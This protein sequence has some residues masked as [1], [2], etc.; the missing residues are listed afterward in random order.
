MAAV[1]GTEEPART[2]PVAIVGI[3]CRFAGADGPEEFWRLLRDGVDAVTELPEGRR[4]HDGPGGGRR[5]SFLAD[6][7]RFD[8]GFFGISPREAAATDPQQRLVLE[9]CWE[10]LED[11]GIVPATLRGGRTGVFVG[12]MRDDYARL[13][14]RAGAA[15]THHTFTGLQRGL[16]A[17]RVSYVCGLRGP[18]LTVDTGQS[19]S[20]TAVHLACRSLLTGESR[21]ALAGGVGLNLDAAGER[22]AAAFGGLSPD[23]R[24]HTFDARANGFVRGE[25]GGIV[26]LK[27]LTAALAAGDRI[28]AVIDGGAVN[29]D[30][31]G[32]GLTVPDRE[33]QEELLRLAY[34]NAG[35]DPARVG[36]VE[37][38]GTGTPVGDPVEAAALG[39]VLGAVRD[40][41]HPLPVGSV[42][43]NLG[44]LEGA[45]GISGLIKAVLAV[46]H[47]EL[48][49][50]LH[51]RS[52]H[53]AIPL[54]AL[55]LRV[56]T[57]L[58]PWA[59]A[60]AA[61]IAGVS[62]FGIG[63]SNCHLVISAPPEPT[64][65]SAPA[66]GDPEAPGAPAPVVACVVSGRTGP[67]LLAQADRLR[68]HVAD[69]PEA[70]PADLAHSLA[71]TRT[72]F[73][74]RAVLTVSDREDLLSGL[75]A[76]AAGRRAPGVVRGTVRPPGRTAFLFAGQGGQRPGMGRELYRAFPAYAEAF[77]A[78][79]RHL[80]PWLDVPLR[81]VVFT[82]G[83]PAAALLDS[84]R[85]TQAAMFT[86]EVALHRLLE[87]FGVRPD[88]VAGH[89]VGELAAAHVADVLSL[90]DAARL[91]AARGRLM[92]SLPPGGAMVA[93]RAAEDEVREVLAAHGDRV[94][95]AAVNGPAATVVSGD[96]DDVAEV[97]ATLTVRGRE[98]RR[99]RIGRALH[100]AHLDPVLDGFRAAMEGLDFRPARLTVVSTLT[101]RPVA[102]DEMSTPEYWIRQARR[103][104]LFQDAVRA[105]RDAGATAFLGL[106]A[107]GS[108]AAM[109]HD[110]LTGA[111]TSPETPGPAPAPDGAATPD[112]RAVTPDDRAVT[113]DGAATPDDGAVT[114]D[115]ARVP[116]G[117]G[118]AGDPVVVVSALRAR[119][120]EPRALF[121]ALG[122]LY[123]R[124]VPV[125]WA[126]AHA[127]RGA[128]RVPL[129][130]YRFQRERYWLD[131]PERPA[132]ADRTSAG[133][134]P[135]TGPAAGGDRPGATAPGARPHPSEAPLD[136][137]L[138][139][140]AGV[141]GHPDPGAV[142]PH[143]TFHD[144][145]FDSLMGVELCER[146]GEEL[147]S[148]LP[149]TVLFDHP[150]PARLARHL[151]SVASAADRPAAPGAPPGAPSR[152]AAGTPG[153]ADAA[154]HDPVVVVGMACSY[155]GGAATPEELWRLAA[156][157]TDA[158]GGFPTDR[159]WDLEALY[160]A[161]PGRAGTSCTRQGGFLH[162]AAEFDAAFFGMSPREALTT[163]P[164]QRLLL[165]TAWQAFESAG[166]DPASVRDSRTA[167]FAGVMHHDYAPRVHTVP[168]GLEG[169]LIT[170]N[171]SS[172]VSGRLSYV[173]G[174]RGPAVTVDTACSS[175][176]VA[177]HLAAQS[178]RRGECTLALAGGVSVMATPEMFV[179]FSRLRAL[180]PDGRCKPFS[181]AADGTAWAEGAGLLVLERL[182]DAR[183]N[184]HRVLAVLRGSAVNQ[185]GASNGLSAPSGPA[186]ERVI[187][188]ALADAGL[189]PA[190][191]DAVEA[192]GTGTPLGDPIEARALLA[193]YGQDRPAG[194]PLLLGSLKSNIGHAQ[195]AAGV[196]GVIKT[197]LA[198]RHGLLPKIL[199]LG[200][201][202]AHVDWDGGGVA[203][204]AE[205]TPWPETGRP[206]RAAVS[207]FGISGTNAHVILEQPPK[208][209]DPPAG[210]TRPD[211]PPVLPWA[212][213]ARSET[214][215][216]ERAAALRARLDDDT[217]TA[218]TAAA[219]AAPATGLADT[220]FTLAAGRSV[221]EHRA[222]IVGRDREALLAGLDAVASGTPAPG[223]FHGTARTGRRPVLVFPGQGTQWAGMGRELLAA[224]PVF[225]AT[226]A[227]CGRALE[228]HVDWSLPEVLADEA[229]LA[230]VDVVQP[231]LWAV[232]VSLAALWTS[233][234]GAPA[235]V[236]GHSQGEIAA[237]TVAGGL[238]LED[239]A[240]VVA[241]RSRAL[242]ELSGAGGMVSVRLS[243]ADTER[244]LRDRAGRIAVAAVNGPASTVVSGDPDALEELCRELAAQE[245]RVSRLPVDYASHSA[246]VERLRDRLLA[247]LAPIAPVTGEVPF[248]STLT[249]EPLDTAR[250]DAAYWYRNLRH[251]V[252]FEPVVRRLAA[253]GHGL[254]VESSPHPVLT[255]DVQQVLDETARGGTAVGSLR[256][257][258]GGLDRFLGSVAEAQVAGAPVRW[259]G[260]FPAGSARLTELPGYPFQRE[261]YWLLPAVAGG[262]GALGLLD[263]GHPLL[264]AGVARADDDSMLFTGSLSQDAYPWTGDHAVRGTVLL[265]GTA[266]LDLAL[267]AGARAGCHRVEE[268]VLETPLVL[269]EHGTVRLQVAV[270]GPDASGCRTVA[271]HSRT[272]GP[273]AEWTRHATGRLSAGAARPDGFADPAA[274]PPPGAEPCD[275]SGVY[276]RLADTGYEYGPAFQGLRAAWRDGDVWY[277]T[278]APDAAAPGATDPYGVHPALLDAALHTLLL[279]GDGG[280]GGG[281]VRLPFS[282]TGVTLHAT[283]AAEL[284]VR[285]S[286]AADGSVALTVADG[287][288]N[289]VASIEALTLRP[290]A[291]EPP[292]HPGRAHHRSLFR[293]DWTEVR[294]PA[295]PT[296]R[297]WALLG[298]GLPEPA[299]TGVPVS[300]HRDMAALRTAIAAGEPVPDVVAVRCPRPA[301]PADLPAGA[302]TAARHALDLV[303][304]WLAD[305]P[306]TARLLV[307]TEGA[308]AAGAGEEVPDLAH[309]TVWG[310]LRSAQSE[311]PGRFGI[312]D[313]EDPAGSAA[314]LRAAVDTGEPQLAVRGGR[315]LAPRL[316]RVPRPAGDRPAVPG[317]LAPDGT[318]LITGGTGTLGGLF[319][320]HL[321]AEHGVRHL[322]LTGRR[323]R[324]AAGAAELA[325]ELAAMGA[326]VTLAACDVSDATALAGVLADIPAAHPLTAVVHA[327][328]VLD[329]GTVT[330]L[331][332]AGLRAVL[333]PKVDGAWHLHT[334]TRHLDLSAF[335]L[336]SSVAGTLGNPGQA[337]Y[338]AANTFLDALAHHRAAQGLP[339]TC[340]SWGLWEQ[341]SGMTAHLAHADRARMARGGLLPLPPAWGTALF[342]TALGADAPHLVPARLDLSGLRDRTPAEA[343]PAP[344]RDLARGVRRTPPAPNATASAP[345]PHGPVP[346]GERTLT[347]LVRT[348]AATV[349]GH[350]AADRIDEH[351]AFRDLGFDSLTGLELR[352]RLTAATGLQLPATL[353][354]DHPTPAALAAHLSGRLPEETG[355]PAPRSAAAGDGDP[356][357]VVGMGCRFPGGADTPGRLW[358]VFA[359]GRDVI[360][361]F[362][363]DRGWP[364][365]LYDEGYGGG[366]GV[367]RPGR[368]GVRHGGFVEGAAEFDAGFFG[369]SPRE[370]LAMDPQHRVLLEV[371]WHTVESAG[372]DPVSLRGSATGVF[373]GLIH[374]DYAARPESVPEDLVG[375]LAIANTP[376]VAS[377][378]IA[379]VLGLHGPALTVDTACSSSL[380]AIHL[381]VRSLRDGETDLALAGGVTLMAGPTHFVEFSQQQALAP[382]GRCKPFSA[383]ADGTGFSEG[384]GMVLLERLSDARRNGHRVL[385]VIRGSAVNQDGASNGL[386]APNG[387][388]QHRVIEAALADARLSADA[389]DA[390]EAH[391]TGTTLGD[392]IELRALLDTYGEG[393]PAD[394]P[395]WLGSAKS[396][397]GHTQAAAGVA[398]V[399]KMVEA[400][401]HGTLP[402]TLHAEVPTPQGDWTS[403]AVRL[404][405]EPRPWTDG[406]RPRRAGVS[407]F[408]I[409]GTNAHL[410]LEQPGPEPEARTGGTTEGVNTAAAVLPVPL[411]APTRQ[412]LAAQASGLLA[413]LAEHPG[414]E[415][416]HLAHSL[417]TTRTHHAH[418]AVVLATDHDR[419]T[420]ALTR[421]TDH[422]P[423][424][425]TVTGHTTPHTTTAFLFP[426]QGTQYPG[427]GA[428][429]HRTFPAFAAAFDAVC[430]E[431]D[432]QLERPLREVVFAPAGSS[433]AD[434]LARTDYAQAA[435]FA[436]EV[437]LFRLLEHF[438][439]T[440]D[441]LAGHSVGEVA[442][443]HVA[444]VLSLADACTLVAARGRLMQALPPGGAMVAL[445]VS[446]EEA[447]SLI[448]GREHEVALAAVN[449]PES[450]VLSGDERAV[451]DCAGRPAARGRRTTRLGAGHAFHSHRMDPMLA[452]FHQVLSTLRFRSPDRTVVSGV[453]GEPVPGEVIGSPEYWTRH[454][455]DT[456]RFH[457]SLR[458][459]A[460]AGVRHGVEV[461]PG[462]TLT[463]LAGPLPAPGGDGDAD[464]PV[465][466]GLRSGHDEAETLL[467]ALANLHTR[468]VPVDWTAW[469]AGGATID[470]PLY[471]FQRE[472]Y[473]LPDGEGA[474][475][476]P[477]APSAAARDLVDPLC[478][479]TVWRRRKPPVPAREALGWLVVA[480]PEE[481][482]DEAVAELLEA[483][484]GRGAVAVPVRSGE[485]G[486]DHWRELLTTRPLPAPPFG[487]VSLLSL[488][489]R[490]DPEQPSV[491]RAVTATLALAQALE[492]AALD[493]PLWCVTAGAVGTGPDDPVHRP[494]QAG[495][496]GL[497]RVIA[498][499]A[500]H[501][502]GGL[503]DLP[504][505][506]DRASWSALCEVLAAPDG[507]DQLAVRPSGVHVPRLVRIPESASAAT[508]DP[509][510]GPP[511]GRRARGTV[512]ITGGLGGLGAHVARRLAREGAEHLLLAGRR[513]P[514][515]PG[516]EALRA[517]LTALGARVTIAACDV[518]D[519]AAL[520]GLLRSVPA[521]TPLSGVVHAAGVLDDGLLQSL[522]PRRLA[523]V[524][525][526]KAGAAWHLHELTRD[527]PLERFVLF[528]S[529]A[530]TAG[531]AGQGNYAAANA[532][533]D[534]LAHHRRGLGLPA[535]ALAWG[536]WEG[537]GMFG[538]VAAR[539]GTHDGLTPMPAP[540]AVDA[541]ERAVAS[542]RPCTVIADADW[543]RFSRGTGRTGALL[544]DV[545][546]DPG[547]AV[548]DGAAA[549]NPMAE[550]LAG[551]SAEELRETLL[552]RVVV[553]TAA[554]SG[555]A[556]EAV[557]VDQPFRELGMDSL[558]TIQLR[559][560][561][562]AETGLVLPTT[563][564]YEHPT[565]AALAGHLTAELGG[566]SADAVRPAV[567]RLRELE[568]VLAS[569]PA[570]DERRSEITALLDALLSAWRHAGAP[571][572]PAPDPHDLDIASDDEMFDLIDNVLG[573]TEG[574]D[575]V[576]DP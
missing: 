71:V 63:G 398:G 279:E 179:E 270:G 426:G 377:G 6:V 565:P 347:E 271:V 289:P 61:R 27:P 511:A 32:A 452:S 90:P 262:A 468:G 441:F 400:L 369:I 250:L 50:S 253:E 145:G 470:V 147:A 309:A 357:V 569:V 91:V 263:P 417:A 5:G 266:L 159:G 222:V 109:A 444:G 463:A 424:P 122:T 363:G 503:I 127:G 453:T 302:H 272:T 525:A 327:A 23:G 379:Y 62:S 365:D 472:R 418:R 121:T 345:G 188:E 322:V 185:D 114:P 557:S 376:S 236:V 386:T 126:A 308:I 205:H 383:A 423:D 364:E 362:P 295:V 1:S 514:R 204:L 431:L 292:G 243:R 40:P 293:L 395:L 561:L 556:V 106:G 81:E 141:L 160:D 537:A 92:E 443:A 489:D 259:T 546:G 9:L 64:G 483:L 156:S 176:L 455:R 436:V 29:N 356:V 465:V 396:N 547:A 2:G 33:A 351:R 562:G 415:L 93:V 507:E 164:Q 143:R 170:G 48:P 559:N 117:D 451:L 332:A 437:A 460:G 158:I 394:R 84:T 388:A 341:P 70:G 242:R 566:R 510:S 13:A 228:H 99:L 352:N 403:G 47:G 249:G 260:L 75:R 220:A 96:G 572:D 425:H 78:V 296:D 439:V 326:E 112:D 95:L 79:C 538:S 432:G 67:A 518:G 282:W 38:H 139:Q 336:F 325:T 177:L 482:Y 397:L 493:A 495:V 133:P 567:A 297:R 201:P 549:G 497:G 346:G 516:A 203:P 123:T 548:P 216:R 462:R 101:G 305:A 248:H 285:L 239:A 206:R 207:S 573:L 409:S 119:Q 558:A 113:P 310:L 433:E 491:P 411:S 513:G 53:P 390:V 330:A 39:A 552:R 477:P 448:A 58:E 422:T 488:D 350:S 88:M 287:A 210:G 55:R 183:R 54:E 115:G 544:A 211:R 56:C 246:Q 268:L 219:P 484:A 190:D 435:V 144:H 494:G 367:P 333:R 349:L 267:H 200:E 387:Q 469:C 389:I 391:G 402:R 94:A 543:T 319:A 314:L 276:E 169:H 194:R 85:Y 430:A 12:A 340:L 59:G 150:T 41:E 155:P 520:E 173:F 300:H 165:A 406:D 232:Q 43:T 311:H 334:L 130:T 18:S 172:V 428:G 186:Q 244:R 26:V 192:H 419:L 36:Y 132:T 42:K 103:P 252:E 73:E 316:V 353:V 218:E 237:A 467:H 149:S 8:A 438:G 445:A 530:G 478:H 195:A 361:G 457:D 45:A 98:T 450:V 80:D 30:G 508:G 104:V 281:R 523:T 358:E 532:V 539:P 339:A 456:V 449:G 410:I 382:D 129:P 278:V 301:D 247:D 191:V 189:T 529:L 434:L 337:N 564:A 105:L 230:R 138:E 571:R 283:G 175:S 135:A 304:S 531:S 86:L 446:E 284:R 374:G 51:F 331:D 527:L 77:D 118:A 162:D 370:A 290:V 416:L 320:R 499:E 107:D 76:L 306:D 60:R 492:D 576:T 373:A 475:P 458:W 487:V 182:S 44:H 479:E 533:L 368:S 257:G 19:S 407:A 570:D 214:A 354:F 408:G 522:T 517:E 153:A 10:A 372:I 15:A 313:V 224:S 338:A 485:G 392:P 524:F 385:A 555:H 137:V 25:G 329:D 509:G 481:A 291:E 342:D 66:D 464:G 57:R 31:G 496:W 568:T 399:I 404:L 427:M 359:E 163:D 535:A 181:A 240:R 521:D 321:V 255:M 235:A 480:P 7:D 312:V 196:G 575:P 83:G 238:S 501:R 274:W 471:A 473:W 447:R 241:L 414:T 506:P 323:G 74:H 401:R 288:G 231:A 102:A 384:A 541:F 519:R 166:I 197:I 534:A 315:L 545:T 551:L 37:L 324:D 28:H 459:L 254:F 154:D 554:V 24:C 199:H 454:A 167:V 540:A 46:R 381:A 500:P 344:L 142:D 21:I 146:L 35:V 256:R 378:R 405:T 360:S 542:S 234:G 68:A 526:V 421:L 553:H 528:S 100:S 498:L 17:N 89:S 574:P 294:P 72:A 108:P 269:P 20:L 11:A 187:R 131:T 208:L 148:E 178:L 213:S 502:W 380:V 225:A 550:H 505:V 69:H 168:D 209:P 258:E 125:D 563:I 151:Q 261:R 420:T 128:R 221:F 82:T 504:A 161:D 328:G 16:I 560:R 429:L 303:Q 265:P 134:S 286:P 140:T 226:M 215:L 343:V 34:R 233:F 171:T 371:A 277:A 273:D 202:T 4:E 223:V 184:G 317:R 193:A 174:L 212:L 124:G 298:A 348:T 264:G 245:V 461:G 136:L 393:R 97:V 217:R 116:D 474:E 198:M 307:L 120:P 466:A 229:A 111:A 442:A 355:R 299:G 515:T 413:H 14:G 335:V 49:P 152:K 536:P 412:G 87:S 275:L 110:C 3:A 366:R 22:E 280:D 157:G 486:R 440:P 251:P 476:R 52:P 490:A 512:L 180:A 65:V 375:Q 318:V 227:A